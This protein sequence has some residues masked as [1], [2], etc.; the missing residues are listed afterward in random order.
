[1]AG[2]SVLVVGSGAREHAF[3]WK[4]RQSSRVGRV[5]CAPGNAGTAALAENVPISAS[6]VDAIAEWSTDRRIDLVVVG[7]EEPLA[8][9]LVDRLTSRSVTTFG[10]P[11]A[12]ARIE[13]SKAWA[14]GVMAEAGVRTARYATFADPSE[15]WA[16]SRAQ[17]Y[18]IVLKADGLAAG[19]GVTVA[20]DPEEARRAIGDVLERGIFGEAGRLLVVEEFLDG[21]ELSLFAFVDGR[22]AL[23]LALARD[24][25]RVG[26]GDT[27]PN[28]GGMGAFAPTHLEGELDAENLCASI[29]RPVVEAMRARGIDY[30]GVLYAG[31]M[32]TSAGPMVVEFNCRLGDPEA[33]VVLPLLGDDLAELALAAA[34]GGLPSAPVSA[35]DGYRCGVVL[36][37]GGYPGAY[38]TGREIRGLEQVDETALVFHAGTRRDENRLV[39]D[40][41]RVLTVVGQGETL[42]V[43]RAHAYANVAR[44]DYDGVQYRRDI[45]R[46]EA[47][48]DSCG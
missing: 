19:K 16:Y 46:K 2:W 20:R 44:I 1:M 37:S 15:A 24:H 9:G 22:T 47:R 13:S 21:E 27:G 6:Q 42:A 11:A 31:L 26:D 14:K 7:P 5:Y 33:Q 36:A 40:G 25:K 12:A 39:T 41:G 45:A 18:P 8:L 3:V 28:T 32:L 23:P 34:T 17:T 43:A 4:L 48:E 29:M 10:P 35:L 38:S 30:R